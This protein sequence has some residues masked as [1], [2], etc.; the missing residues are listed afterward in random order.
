MTLEK[1]RPP[2][3]EIK[4]RVG[5]E[6]NDWYLFNAWYGGIVDKGVVDENKFLRIQEAVQDGLNEARRLD[7]PMV[8][9]DIGG[10][11]NPLRAL[12]LASGLKGVI[13]VDPCYS[14][15]EEKDESYEK[16][17]ENY[18]IFGGIGEKKSMIQI[19]KLSLNNLEI[20]RRIEGS[21]PKL[22]RGKR[23]QCPIAIE[24]VPEDACAWIVNNR[25]QRYPIVI[26]WR[27]FLPAQIWGYVI[28]TIMPGGVLIT[29][30]YGSKDR[31]FTPPGEQYIDLEDYEI[32]SCGVDIDN[33]PLPRNGNSQAIGLNPILLGS[34]MYFY[35]KVNDLP[36]TQVT[37]ALLANLV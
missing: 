3:I 20:P 9:L 30:G 21:E 4:R 23:R 10:G 7:Y 5:I 18:H 26:V 33:T 12:P 6:L 31:L 16:Y 24:L 11:C 15:Y 19:L 17:P 36:P 13:S 2:L 1:F 34:N 14:Y 25:T 35:R 28:E 8:A 32:V 27:T 37:E 22:I 29:T